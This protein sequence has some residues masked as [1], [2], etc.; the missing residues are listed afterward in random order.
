MP[1]TPYPAVYRHRFTP[2]NIRTRR[3]KWPECRCYRPPLHS[4]HE[5]LYIGS[6]HHRLHF[7]NA[8]FIPSPQ[9]RSTTMPAQSPKPCKLDKI[10]YPIPSHPISLN[11]PPVLKKCMTEYQAELLHPL[12]S[13]YP[14][15]SHPHQTPPK[16]SF[17][18]I[19]IPTLR[20]LHN[21]VFIF[22]ILQNRKRS[23]QLSTKL[24]KDEKK[25]RHIR[26]FKQRKKIFFFL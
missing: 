25:P 11:P 14:T 16:K 10:L 1:I 22:S 17:G 21:I 15:L 23:P 2:I 4:L 20:Q 3:S 6:Y 13:P 8:E 7:I 12:A 5:P 19:R 24:T 18:C 26:E 9:T